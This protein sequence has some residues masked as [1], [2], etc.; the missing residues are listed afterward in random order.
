MNGYGLHQIVVSPCLAL[1]NCVASQGVLMG[2]GVT[3]IIAALRPPHSPPLFYITSRFLSDSSL[4]KNNKWGGMVVV[5]GLWF[6][7]NSVKK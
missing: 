6:S 5:V 1:L 3:T 4:L 2:I 7:L